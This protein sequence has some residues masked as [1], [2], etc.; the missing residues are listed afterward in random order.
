MTLEARPAGTSVPGGSNLVGKVP[1]E[2]QTNTA[3]VPPGWE[4]GVGP[5]PHLVR[6]P[7]LQKHRTRIH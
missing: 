6:D 4:F 5:I 1:G 3:P 7:L 2:G